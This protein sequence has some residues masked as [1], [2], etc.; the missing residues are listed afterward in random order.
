MSFYDNN[1]ILIL[2][3]FSDFVDYVILFQ[4]CDGFVDLMLVEIFMKI[5]FRNLVNEIV[6]KLNKWNV[7]LVLKCEGIWD[8]SVFVFSIGV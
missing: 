8:V 2:L 4:F 1:Y 6:S 7:N 3:G 5:I